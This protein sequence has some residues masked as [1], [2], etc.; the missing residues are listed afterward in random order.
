[1]AGKLKTYTTKAGFYELAVAATSMKAALE[2]WG[3]KHNAFADGTAEISK[4]A[5]V[6]ATAEARPGLVLRRPIGSKAAF[7]ENPKGLK[8]PRPPKGFKKTTSPKKDSAAVKRAQDSLARAEAAHG[9]KL[10]QFAKA[11]RTLDAEEEAE[12]ERWQGARDTLRSAVE[13]AK[14]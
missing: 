3:M 9:A 10:E 11:R 5:S 12:R 13:K 1:M 14:R 7:Q 6:I 8:A 2:A 4:N